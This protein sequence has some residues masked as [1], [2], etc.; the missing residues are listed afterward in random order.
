MG[1]GCRLILGLRVSLGELS[2][3]AIRDEEEILG[4]IHVVR[5][6]WM[7]RFGRF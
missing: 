1:G 4:C 6:K 7:G 2:G 5:K 3:G